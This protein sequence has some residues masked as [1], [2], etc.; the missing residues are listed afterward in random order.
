VQRRIRAVLFDLDGVVAFTDRFH[1]QAWKRLADEQG[2]QFDERVNHRLRGVPRLA[3]L[4]IILE[5]NGL[6]LPEPEQARLAD[7]KN[8]YYGQLLDGIGSGDLYPG[9]VDLLQRLRR[10]GAVLGLCSSSRNADTVL[11]RLGLRPLFD[12][13]VTGNDIRRAKPDPEIFLLGAERLGVPASQ[14]LVFEDA[15][16]GIE[17]ALAGHMAAVGVGTA[18]DLPSAPAVVKD[19]GAIDVDVLL[20]TGGLSRP[21]R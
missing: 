19:Y 9:V 11:D 16:A 14:C 12:A 3:S 1:Y 6:T 2:W 17:A 21:A 10:A 15:E 13:V 4:Q 5:H 18:A 8:R 20:D 7:I